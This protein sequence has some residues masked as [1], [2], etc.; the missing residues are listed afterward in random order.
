MPSTPNIDS[1]D[2]WENIVEF[3]GK[4][5][6]MDAPWNRHYDALNRVYGWDDFIV[7]LKKDIR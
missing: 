4:G 5:F 6:L 7:Q 3:K 1:Y 2:K